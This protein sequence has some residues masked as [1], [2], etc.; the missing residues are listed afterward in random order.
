M[1]TDHKCVD[2]S[3]QVIIMVKGGQAKNYEMTLSCRREVEGVETHFGLK[4]RSWATI[5]EFIHVPKRQP[6]LSPCQTGGKGND[7]EVMKT[8]PL[9]QTGVE[10]SALC[11]GCMNMRS[12]VADEVSKTILDGYWAAGG[13]FLDTANCYTHWVPG[14]QG[15]ESEALVGE[16]MQARQNRDEL[17]LATKVGVPYPD[18]PDQP[19][20]G[21]PGG[22]RA[23]EI[24]RECDKSL[25]RLGT[26]YID[27][28]YAH[29]EDRETPME[30]F[31]E[32][33]DRLVKVGKVRHVGVSNFLP[34]RLQQ[35]EMISQQHGWASFCCTQFRYSYVRQNPAG[36]YSVHLYVNRDMLD[37]CAAKQMP[38]V[39]FSPLVKGGLTD[40][41]RLMEHLKGPDT[42]ARLKALHAMAQKHQASVNQIAL[43]WMMARQDV[44]IIPLFSASSMEQFSENIACLKVTLSEEDMTYLNDASG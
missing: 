44:R 39:A 16:W 10:V 29:R 34:W 22:L 19:G 28:Y 35:A 23:A 30:E 17:F 41:G 7:W 18:L 8:V 32:A 5:S 43:A 26:D 9:G 25:Q 27:L 37:Y 24:Q 3:E 6:S 42:D 33:F 2:I 31:L 40:P 1:M 13:R 21:S 12:R 20:S 38:I 36:S 4:D 15:G 11:L 14:G